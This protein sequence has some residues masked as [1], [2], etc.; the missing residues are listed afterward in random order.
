MNTY[1]F[2]V[3]TED[4]ARIE[5]RGLSQ[6]TAIMMYNLTTK[7]TRTRHGRDLKRYGWEE[8]KEVDYHV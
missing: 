6:R 7:N 2:Y 8:I 4:G 3:E 5:W 1:M